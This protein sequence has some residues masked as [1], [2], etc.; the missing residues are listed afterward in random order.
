MYRDRQPLL[1]L[2]KRTTPEELIESNEILERY[3]EISLTQIIDERTPLDELVLSQMVL[4]EKGE[5]Q[6]IEVAAIFLTGQYKATYRVIS[7]FHEV[8]VL[9]QQHYEDLSRKK[10]SVRVHYGKGTEWLLD[11]R[12]MQVRQEKVTQFAR[13]AVWVP[14][15]MAAHP[16]N[17]PELKRKI[18]HG[19]VTPSRA[20]NLR[21]DQRNSV[22]RGLTL[23]ETRELQNWAEEKVSL[24]KLNPSTLAINLKTAELA[25]PELTAK[26]RLRKKNEDK[27]NTISAIL[28]Q[29]V[30]E[31]FPRNF[32]LQ[33]LIVKQLFQGNIEY[34]G[35]EA[36]VDKL[37]TAELNKGEFERVLS[38]P[39]QKNTE[40]KKKTERRVSYSGKSGIHRHRKQ[41]A[42]DASS[43]TSPKNESVIDDEQE[44]LQTEL[45]H[46]FDG[47]KIDLSNEPDFFP[48]RRVQPNLRF[49][50][51][52]QSGEAHTFLVDTGEILSSSGKTLECLSSEE[53]NLLALWLTKPDP[54]LEDKVVALYGEGRRKNRHLI[55]L[56]LMAETHLKQKLSQLAVLGQPTR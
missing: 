37:K 23:P 19:I 5:P 42:N 14:E 51:T 38:Q 11:Q 1:P 16:W 40:P 44:E 31:K 55:P 21:A 34:S 24:W 17:S 10:I 4:P 48:L 6:D 8:A 41:S 9:K 25:A 43:D 46:S 13:I 29:T 47:G 45:S 2:R 33:K 36:W 27:S 53:S 30:V 35:I 56:V 52:N 39:P 32:V 7:G 26:V 18:E 22:P 28:L 12:L 49:T 15:A 3:E 50:L 20:F 54:T